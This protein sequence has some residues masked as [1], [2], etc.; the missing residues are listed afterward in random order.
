MGVG[1]PGNPE[2]AAPIAGNAEAVPPAEPREAPELAADEPEQ[3]VP[4]TTV[5]WLRDGFL[6]NVVSLLF[7]SS[8]LVASMIVGAVIWNSGYKPGCITTYC[9]KQWAWLD[10]L[11]GEAESYCSE[12]PPKLTPFTWVP[13]VECG[14]IYEEKVISV[15]SL[16]YLTS[17]FGYWPDFRDVPLL[18]G[19]GRWFELLG[20]SR[21]VN[22]RSIVISFWEL[23]LEILLTLIVI[24][25]LAW[26]GQAT[27]RWVY[28]WSKWLL[29]GDEVRTGTLTDQVDAV[30]VT[31]RIDQE[32]LYYLVGNVAY[33]P[34][35]SRTMANLIAQGRAWVS[36]NRKRWGERESTS[37]IIQAATQ[38]MAVT[39]AE[40]EA[41]AF[42]ASGRVYR[43][44]VRARDVVSGLLN[45]GRSLPT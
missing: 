29:V 36:T 11:W 1:V 26:L 3:P 38:A 45:W 19:P 22:R 28:A 18:R 21:R 9:Y 10:Y 8:L 2:P 14:V 44:L 15:N 35:D 40:A 20:I 17:P 13:R 32:L 31:K 41:F 27:I 6:H 24:V 30:A 34:R 16:Y 4:A 37:Q 12:F 25:T 7:A 23:R 5:E 43:G 42:L 33:K 39:A